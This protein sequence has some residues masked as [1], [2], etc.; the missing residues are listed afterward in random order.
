MEY[1]GEV[2]LI[3][4]PTCFTFRAATDSSILNGQVISRAES[5][6]RVATT[7]KGWSAYYFLD[8]D[9]M[10]VL[11][12]VRVLSIFERRCLPIPRALA[13]AHWCLLWCSQGRKGNNARFINHS[14]G[15]NTHVARWKFANTDEFQVSLCRRDR[16]R[17]LR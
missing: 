6:K 2:G 9:G 1:T 11:D 16:S 3:R 4:T 14:C 17:D 15:P 8:Y 7:Y 10:E 5:Y 12:A 13:P